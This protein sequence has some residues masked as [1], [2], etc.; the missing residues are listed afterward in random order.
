MAIAR[1]FLSN[2]YIYHLVKKVV[3][4]KLSMFGA[5]TALSAHFR[6]IFCIYVDI[7]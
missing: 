5:K 4:Q 2:E 7:K 6:M 1:I 3:S